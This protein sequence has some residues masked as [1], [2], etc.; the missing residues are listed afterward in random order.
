MWS[1]ILERVPKGVV[2][3]F[4]WTYFL[5]RGGGLIRSTK[6]QFKDLKFGEIVFF[7]Q[8]QKRGV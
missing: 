4:F 1:L 7:Y 3:N 2:K 8:T 6:I 5:P